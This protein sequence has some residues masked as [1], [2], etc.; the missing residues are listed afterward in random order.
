MKK[1]NIYSI[2]IAFS[3]LFF[4]GCGK[5]EKLSLYDT[6]EITTMA[7]AEKSLKEEQPTTAEKEAELQETKAGTSQ[8]ILV[9]IC[10]AVCNPGVYELDAGSRLHQLVEKAGG[11]S[12]EAQSDYLNLAAILSDGQKI[13][14][15]TKEEV[16]NGVF[17]PMMGSN[18]ENSTGAGQ[19]IDSSGKETLVNINT[20]GEEQLLTL[21]GIGESKAKSIIAY[22]N[23][24]SGF[25]R[26]ED[27][28]NITG[29]KQAVYDKIKDKI[30]VQ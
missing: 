26:K 8:K 17:M 23:E 6:T 10:G 22:R 1:C 9:H 27:I 20:A 13:Q 28:M 12:G 29:I 3:L 19:G 4:C 11:M 16:K 15:P 21:P 18:V 5:K 14:V 2:L 25:S 7:S 24:H 30:C